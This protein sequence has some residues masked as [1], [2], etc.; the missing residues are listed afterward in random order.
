MRGH[1]EGAFKKIA[2]PETN[3][4]PAGGS[5]THITVWPGKI[6]MLHFTFSIPNLGINAN[7]KLESSFALAVAPLVLLNSVKYNIS[8]NIRHLY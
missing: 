6:H 5:C 1:G 3:V 4:I 8:F 7:L 2:S